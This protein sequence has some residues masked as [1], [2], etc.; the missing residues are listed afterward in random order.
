MLMLMN[1]ILT[2]RFGRN[3]FGEWIGSN[4]ISFPIIKQAKQ[5]H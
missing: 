4:K 3:Y 5:N 1:E 2:F